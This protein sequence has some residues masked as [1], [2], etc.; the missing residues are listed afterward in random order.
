MKS[1]ARHMSND[2][3]A[4]ACVVRTFPDVRLGARIARVMQPIITV[5]SIEDKQEFCSRLRTQED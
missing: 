5:I 3:N 2:N 4:T 1:C